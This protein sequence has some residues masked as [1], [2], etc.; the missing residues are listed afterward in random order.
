MRHKQFELGEKPGALLSRQLRGMQASR[1]IHKIKPSL[2]SLTTDPA[3][4]NDCV[5]KYYEELYAQE[6]DVVTFL[7]SLPLPKLDLNAQNEL[8]A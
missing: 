2:S 7:H 3:K 6:A 5:M 1:A 8:N 4:I